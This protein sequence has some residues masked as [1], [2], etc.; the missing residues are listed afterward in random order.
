MTAL[1]DVTCNK[2]N[3]GGATPPGNCPQLIKKYQ[4][5]LCLKA[6]RALTDAQRSEYNEKICRQLMDMPCLKAAKT[7]FSYC[8]AYDEADPGAFH[9]WAVSQGKQIAYPV[10]HGKGIMEARIP[11]DDASWAE[12]SYGIREPIRERS[13]PVPPEKTDAILIPCVGFDAE[14]RRLGH[15]AGYYDRYLPACPGAAR[16]CVAFEAQRLEQIMQDRTDQSMDAI[17]TEKRVYLA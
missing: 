6:R 11:W 2:N 15:G 12:G 7:I 16:V 5:Q 14:G 13:T 8:A 1:G 4:R 10:T 17:V 9:R 3:G